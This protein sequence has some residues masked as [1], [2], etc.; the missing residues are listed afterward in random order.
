M[1]LTYN[2]TRLLLDG[3]LANLKPI[4]CNKF[5]DQFGSII[6]HYGF[7]SPRTHEHQDLSRSAFVQNQLT[8]TLSY[9][10]S[11]GGCESE[12]TEPLET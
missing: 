4:I 3:Y 9:Q 6:T 1:S 7:R 12:S 11:E 2:I 5:S 10:K 8:S